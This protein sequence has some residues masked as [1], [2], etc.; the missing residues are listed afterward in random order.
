MLN[1]YAVQ[2]LEDE[3]LDALKP[4]L[5]ELLKDDDKNKQRG[6]AELLAGVLSGGWTFSFVE[7]FV[8]PP[9]CRVETLA[10]GTAGS[11]LGLVQTSYEQ[12]L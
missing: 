2:L 4:T 3:P 1:R 12:G 8:H 9:T 7:D 5:D 10:N 11:T 6:A